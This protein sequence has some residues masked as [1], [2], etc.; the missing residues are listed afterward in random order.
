MADEVSLKIRAAIETS[1]EER[2]ANTQKALEDIEKLDEKTQSSKQTP[3]Q[4]DNLQ[5]KTDNSH[6]KATDEY[7]KQVDSITKGFSMLAKSIESPIMLLGMFKEGLFN[8]A[9]HTAQKADQLQMSPKNGKSSNKDGDQND[10]NPVGKEEKEDPVEQRL[11]IPTD[12]KQALKEKDKSSEKKDDEEKA[13]PAEQRLTI[14]TDLK[15]ALKEKDKSSEKKNDEE[16]RL[17]VPKSAETGKVSDLPTVTLNKKANLPNKMLG[18]AIGKFAKGLGVAGGALAGLT[19]VAIGVDK[20]LKKMNEATLAAG[21]RMA[22]LQTTGNAAGADLSEWDNSLWGSFVNSIPILGA[23]IRGNKVEGVADWTA[24]QPFA[25]L[26]PGLLDYKY[27]TGSEGSGADVAKK[28]TDKTG[29]ETGYDF[30]TRFGIMNKMSEYTGKGGN[31]AKV[32]KE[33]LSNARALGLDPDMLVDLVGNELRYDKDNKVS[34]ASDNND[35]MT[36]IQKTA[37][38]TG[39]DRSRYKELIR[40]FD[41][42]IKKQISIGVPVKVENV[43]DMAG[44][45]GQAGDTWKGEQGLQIQMSMSD[46]LRSAGNL[47]SDEDVALMQWTMGENESYHDWRLEMDKGLT[48]GRFKTMSQRFIKETGEDKVTGNLRLMNAFGLSSYTQADELRKLMIKMNGTDPESGEKLNNTT[49]EE[50]QVEFQKKMNEIKDAS[51]PPELDYLEQVNTTMEQTQTQVTGRLDSILNVLQEHLSDKEAENETQ[52]VSPER[53]HVEIRLPASA[54][55][56][57]RANP[58][59]NLEGVIAQMFRKKTQEELPDL[60][61]HNLR[62]KF[63]KDEN[64]KLDK[65]ETNEYQNHLKELIDA[66]RPLKDLEE[67]KKLLEGG[68]VEN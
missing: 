48:E 40:G 53:Q 15:Q 57:P 25:K 32:T 29:I 19:A 63:D 36:S 2:L 51:R 24:Y 46:R 9:R 22:M 35:I 54:N 65:D 1:G 62:S 6:S 5:N 50:A 44:I 20:A 27:K 38:D 67:I 16:K 68:I 7:L 4:A 31:D 49:K 10:E 30:A 28:V 45:L 56:N 64:N 11:T 47:T 14:P 26:I 23:L 52:A 33:L 37:T 60:W 3:N 58:V 43:S 12:L 18:N 55:H 41:E 13:N 21:E 17:S 34:F 59:Y 66:L 42:I 39:L 8:A 61:N